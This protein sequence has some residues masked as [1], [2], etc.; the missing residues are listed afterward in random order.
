MSVTD[1]RPPGPAPHVVWDETRVEALGR[2]L[3]TAANTAR[4]GLAVVLLEIPEPR[5]VYLTDVG[6]EILGHPKSAVLDQP[7]MAFLTPEERAARRSKGNPSG[8]LPLS[9]TN[10]ET[11][12]LTADRRRVPVEVSL[13]PVEAE[14]Q[15]MVVVFFRDISDRHASTEALRRSE[16]RFRRL[17]EVAPDA[18]WINDGRRLLYVNE[19][20]QRMLGYDTLAEVTALNPLD[21]V[22]P[23][24]HAPMIARSRAMMASGQPL[25]PREYRIRRRDGSSVMTE[26]QS[27][28]VD[29]EGQKAILGFAR[30][31]TA[32][33][34]ME[35]QLMRADRLAALGTLLAGIAHEMNNPLAYV[36]LGI[37]QAFARVD[38]LGGESP[39]AIRL[40]EVLEDV[41][42]GTARVA[43]VVR[44]L[45]VTS[46]PDTSDQ[47]VVDVGAALQSALRIAGN[48]IR[49]RARLRTELGE[50]AEVDGS[51]QRLEQVFLNL[52]VNA[53]QA[54]PE[55]RPDNEIGVLLYRSGADRIVVEISDNGHGIAP[56]LLPRIFDPFF[57]TKAVGVGMGLGLSIC[58]GI[59]TGHGGTIDVDS[60]VGRG[61]RFRVSLP[62]RGTAV[63]GDAPIERSAPLAASPTRRR[64]ILVVDDEPALGG[65]IQR[66]L[67]EDCDV[68]VVSDGRQ[69]L[70]RLCDPEVAY[71]TVLC[72]LM[73]PEMTGME[74]HALVAERKPGVE[75]RFVFMTGGAF[76]QRAAEFLA[77]MRNPRLDK[78]FDLAALRAIVSKR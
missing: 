51:A 23:E 58:H 70:V 26:V 50:M 65:M 40:R 11:M 39:A 52:L 21:I 75:K 6:A 64:R 4:I 45:R 7:A 60:E 56:D 41:R 47:G 76:T 38:E 19:A 2:S 49:H 1:S 46:R 31:V 61:T 42:T 69:G 24:D 77:T 25:P 18:V 20:T 12:V 54:L 73:M 63:P 62:V 35:T 9:V 14:G 15:S 28:P 74:L 17:I 43:A 68:D 36:M 72:D 10:F 48:E 71:D 27:M 66:M 67:R 5:I 78:P 29:W 34:E 57:T 30:D 32:R 53:T 13:A 44:Q 33:K 22:H 8:Q 3:V 37:E 55:G 16:E 59:V